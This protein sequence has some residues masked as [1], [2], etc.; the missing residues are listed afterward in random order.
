MA[1]SDPVQIS[2]RAEHLAAQSAQWNSLSGAELRGLYDKTMDA[3]VALDRRYEAEGR[4]A[5]QEMPDTE[6]PERLES[7]KR[8]AAYN[9]SI[10]STP[11][12]SASNPFAGVDRNQLTSIIYDDTGAY[13][14]SERYAAWSEQQ[15]QDFTRL[16]AVFEGITHG[17]DNRTLYKTLLDY[18]D[19]MS[20]VEQS[21]YPKDYRER[22]EDFLEEQELRFGASDEPQTLETDSPKP[23]A[24]TRD[25]PIWT[26]LVALTERAH[27][28]LQ[29][30]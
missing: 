12:G 17:G 10:R 7:A 30:D 28:S 16:D 19:E 22:L 23:D 29:S 8:A 2:A 20:P 26:Q 21:I 4:A 13:T 25:R 9:D 14:L 1:S 3:F 27:V 5:L 24:L 15:R 6:D 18:F 11:R